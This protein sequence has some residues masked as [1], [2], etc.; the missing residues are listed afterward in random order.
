VGLPALSAATPGPVLLRLEAEYRKPLAYADEVLVTARAVALRRTSATMEYAAWHEG[1]AARCTAVFVLVVAA[2][3]ERA[4]IPAGV[5]A[6]M[7]ARDAAR[8]E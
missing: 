8:Q 6:A 2:T 3:G 4:A 7:L 5:R 1:L